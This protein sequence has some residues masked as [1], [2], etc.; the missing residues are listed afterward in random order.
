VENDNGQGVFLKRSGKTYVVLSTARPTDKGDL[1]RI[2][3]TL[4]LRD[5][6]TISACAQRKLG[7]PSSGRNAGVL[8]ICGRIVE[9]E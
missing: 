1:L 7:C 6:G 8:S 3:N 2:T 9:Q 4:K 5:N